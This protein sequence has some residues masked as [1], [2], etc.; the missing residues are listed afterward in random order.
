MIVTLHKTHT[1]GNK[2]RKNEK[3]EK[4]GEKGTKRFLA[5]CKLV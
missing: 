2:T 4:I 1:R 5:K 3:T